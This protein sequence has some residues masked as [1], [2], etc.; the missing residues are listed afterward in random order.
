MSDTQR[1]CPDGGCGKY[2]LCPCGTSPETIIGDL[3]IHFAAPPCMH[4]FKGW[5]EFAD[6]G[7]EQVCTK[8]GMGA[9]EHTMRNDQ[10]MATQPVEPFLAEHKRRP[11]AKKDGI[12][13]WLRDEI[14]YLES[15]ELTEHG[16][17]A[18]AA[19]KATLREL[20]R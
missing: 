19:Y 8:C 5:R 1:A 4:D 17:G 13:A 7:G 18:L 12:A 15:I 6:G 2:P 20:E 14:A 16:N 10:T 11:T 3:F 9:M